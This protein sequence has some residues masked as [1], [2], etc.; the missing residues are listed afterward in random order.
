MRDF[1]ATPEGKFMVSDM[2]ASNIV[3]NR[4]SE[5]LFNNIVDQ[6]KVDE[7]F[8]SVQNLER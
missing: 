3:T 4:K 6:V 8:F 1:H 7:T 2:I 5:I